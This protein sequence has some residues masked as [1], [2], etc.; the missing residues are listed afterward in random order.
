MEPLI[1][2]TQNTFV[3]Y[4]KSLHA[5]KG[6]MQSAA[7][8]VEGQ[9]CVEEL[10]ASWPESLDTLIIEE[11]KYFETADVVM[12][13]GGRV[14][15]VATHVMN[16]ICDS[17]TPQG[18]AAI[19]KIPQ[20]SLSESGFIIAL[21]DVQDPQNVG[22]II[23][24]ADAAGCAGVVLSGSSAD[25]YSPKA[26]RASMGSLFHLPVVYDELENVLSSLLEQGY[27]VACA[28]LSGNIDFSLE[29]NKT[30]LVIGNEARGISEEV[31]RLSTHRV[32]IPI[33]GRAES[34]NAAV[35]AG[36]L[37]YKIRA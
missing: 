17:K 30:C 23:R 18:I 16:A 10:V 9:K 1:T 19:A 33:F 37:I 2:S 36:I 25:C 6:R 27:S 20:T 32:R 34:L 14:S 28:D 13:K 24:T 7:F 4:V 8:L 11:G 29:P 31:L 26:V 12:Q 35:A 5:K 15:R 3:K 22:T 21:D